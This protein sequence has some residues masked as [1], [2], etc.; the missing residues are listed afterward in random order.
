MGYVKKKT[1]SRKHDEKKSWTHEG[2]SIQKKKR[3]SWTLEGPSIQ[4]KRE[5]DRDSPCPKKKE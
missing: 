4:K 2:P 5:R 3:E 1:C